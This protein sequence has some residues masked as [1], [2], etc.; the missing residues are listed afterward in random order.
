MDSLSIA[1]ILFCIMETANVMILYFKPNSRLGNGVA[2]FDAWE[3]TKQDKS[4]ELF[5]YYMVY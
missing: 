3:D 5:A 1:I 4:M 2:I